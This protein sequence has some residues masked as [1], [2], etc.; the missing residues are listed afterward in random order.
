[1]RTIFRRDTWSSADRLSVIV[2]NADLSTLSEMDFRLVSDFDR[3]GEEMSSL[4]PE[5]KK[6][7]FELIQTD[8]L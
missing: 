7:V 4:K 2:L 8:E 3:N 5:E 1:M 6:T